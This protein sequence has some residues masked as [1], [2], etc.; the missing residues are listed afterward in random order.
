MEQ[1]RT[2]PLTWAQQSWM[3]VQGLTEHDAW[4][5]EIG[6]LVHVPRHV[7]VAEASDVI[8][9]LAWS[10]PPL[11]ARLRRA[12]SA[13]VQEL[14]GAD[15]RLT[16]SADRLTPSV[17]VASPDADLNET[18]ER[19]RT[20]HAAA[21]GLNIAAVVQ[22]PDPAKTAISVLLAHAFVD[23]WGVHALAG[24]IDQ[25]F[26][27]GQAIKPQS[28]LYDLLRFEGSASGLQHSQRN[29]AELIRTAKRAAELGVLPER[30]V[31]LSSGPVD[32]PTIDYSNSWLPR[33]LISLGGGSRVLRAAAML[34]LVFLA[35]CSWTG[36]R[37]SAV[38]QTPASNRISDNEREFVGLLMMRTW[39]LAEWRSDET[40]RQLVRRL[41]RG[42]VVGLTH[43]RFEP[44]RA[45]DELSRHG[46]DCPPQ[47]YFNYFEPSDISTRPPAG[48]G[49]TEI[50]WSQ[51]SARWKMAPSGGVPFEY[52]A[53]IYHDRALVVTKFDLDAFGG[54]DA[55]LFAHRLKRL[56]AALLDDPELT[57]GHACDLAQLHGA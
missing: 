57:V 20:E 29:I 51:E 12:G 1:V 25:H 40:C 37:R 15:S 23:G 3:Q 7:S 6:A 52:N 45:A 26:G 16:Q 11:R 17:F 46:F 30:P 22:Y 2:L 32:L 18:T 42:L 5:H 19:V 35:Y 54:A 14:I 38:F 39:V 50:P 56:A 41:A 9:E 31:G 55:G 53:Y 24:I 36:N 4:R 44:A 21:G 49:R 47:L 48:P 27:G 34:S 43:G 10:H 13:V 28:T 8:T 33:V